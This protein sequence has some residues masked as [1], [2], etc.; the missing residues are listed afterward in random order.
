MSDD[1]P[2][3]FPQSADAV[4]ATLTELFRHQGNR[5]A[6]DVLEKIEHICVVRRRVM[7]RLTD[8]S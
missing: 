1:A 7:G 4:V 2:V 8:A 5:E 6:C 3:A